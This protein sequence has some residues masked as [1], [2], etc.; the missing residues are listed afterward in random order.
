VPLDPMV[1]DFLDQMAAMGGPKMWEI[2][3]AQARELF[4][5]MM[6]LVG[7][8]D[9][10]IGKVQNLTMPG[11]GGEL[12]LRNYTPVAAKSEP[13][14]TLVFYHGGGFVIG[15]LDTHDGLCRM[16]ANDA[17]VR[18][19]A[20]DYRL[21]PESKYP[22]AV[23]DA[24]AAVN[25]IEEH[26][27]D[28][29]VDA[30]RVAVGGDSAGGALAAIVSQQAKLKGAPKVAFQLLMFPVTQVNAKTGSM[31]TNADGYFLELATL[32][33][34]YDHY[35]A[36]ADVDKTDPRISPLLAKD[37]SGLPPAYIITAEYDPLRDDGA[38]YAEKLRKAGVSVT[39]VDYPGLVHDFIYMQTVLPQ[40]P[41]AM[42]A[43]AAALKGALK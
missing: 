34:F 5:A 21:S 33:W 22:A 30:N 19:I 12:R 29:G 8:K 14:P 18:V 35:G 10:P 26:A 6:Q 28:L 20:V 37:V 13:L 32:E 1:K 17:G 36:N 11:P 24:I 31:H 15:N 25:W 39:H 38:Q 41:E 16:L 9:V 40:A 3:P 23:D 27:A 42:K 4:I 43:A 7:P 2:E